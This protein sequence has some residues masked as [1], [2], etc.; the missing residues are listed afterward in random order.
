MGTRDSA[1]INIIVVDN[2]STAL[3]PC[4]NSVKVKYS[5][6][7]Y[8]IASSA[9]PEHKA[10][11]DK[12]RRVKIFKL[13]TNTGRTYNVFD[14]TQLGTDHDWCLSAQLA[15][16]N[17]VVFVINCAAY[18]PLFRTSTSAPLNKDLSLFSSSCQASRTKEAR[19]ILWIDGRVGFRKKIDLL[20]LDNF[21]SE[22]K[23]GMS[24]G[25]FFENVPTRFEELGRS[26]GKEVH[27]LYLYEG[28]EIG[29]RPNAIDNSVLQLEDLALKKEK[30]VEVGH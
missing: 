25:K 15:N 26:H 12:E 7:L 10:S 6:D 21:V 9:Y 16:I 20:D 3:A 5:G 30:E 23:G 17:T 29:A 19:L 27:S 8:S 11:E 2:P 28:L 14:A 24:M 4:W 1:A 18:D 22:Y 13:G